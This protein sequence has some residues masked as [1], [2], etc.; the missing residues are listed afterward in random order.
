MVHNVIGVDM[1]YHIRIGVSWSL[2]NMWSLIGI[3]SVVGVF[4]RRRFI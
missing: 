1:S 3:V 4:S 2:V